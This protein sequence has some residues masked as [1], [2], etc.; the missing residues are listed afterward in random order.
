M[1]V[2][3]S[4][5]SLPPSESDWIPPQTLKNGAGVECCLE[6]CRTSGLASWS[7]DPPDFTLFEGTK[8]SWELAQGH[9]G[10]TQSRSHPRTDAGY[11][12]GLQGTS[13]RKGKAS[14]LLAARKTYCDF[15]NSFL[16]PSETSSGL[17]SSQGPSRLQGALWV[18]SIKTTLGCRPSWLGVEGALGGWFMPDAQGSMERQQSAT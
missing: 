7:E 17:S 10:P 2:I 18:G 4:P 14:L 15:L 6:G 16:L 8:V 9:Q 13:L 3:F 11:F 1:R 12:P 5:C